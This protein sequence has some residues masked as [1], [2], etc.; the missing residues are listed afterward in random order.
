ML[1]ARLLRRTPLR[2]TMLQRLA[3]L[4]QCC[5]TATR[6][7]AVLLLLPD[8]T[9]TAAR[10]PLTRRGRNLEGQCGLEGAGAPLVAR[11]T[12][13]LGDLHGAAVASVAAGRLSSMALLHGSAYSWGDGSSGMLGLGAGAN[14]ASPR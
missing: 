11:P 6:A 4:Q 7:P 3:G 1:L 5:S 10:T 13:V 12:P 8:G 2:G 14:V 9:H